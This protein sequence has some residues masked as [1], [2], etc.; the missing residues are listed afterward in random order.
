MKTIKLSAFLILL[1]SWSIVSA[2]NKIGQFDRSTAI[3]DCKHEGK[4]AYSEDNQTYT[5]SGS[6]TNMWFGSD[7]FQYLWTTIQG[8]FI[9]RTEVAFVGEGVDPH[10]KVGW[11][12]KNSLDP[13]SKHVNASTH[14][15]GLTSL[16]YRKEI[17]ADTEEVVSTA[18]HPDVIQLERKGNTFI[19]S[20]A[21]FGEEFT[22]VTLDAVQLDTEVYIGIYMCSHNPEVVESAIYRNVRIIKPVEPDFKPYRDYIGSNLEIMDVETGQREIIYQSAH[23]IQA[24]NWTVDGKK[25]IYNSKGRLYNYELATHSISSLN[26]GFAVNNNNDHVLTFDGKLLGISNHNQDDGGTSAIYYLPTEGDSLP[27]LVTKKGVG[28]SYFHGWSPDNK[29]MVFTGNRGGAYNIHTVD[30][31]SGKEEKLTDLTTLDDGPE[32]SPDGKHIFFNSARTGTMQLW[33]MKANGKKQTQL[34][35]DKYNDWFPHVSPDKKWIAFI[36]FPSDI[37]P[38]DHPFYKHCL[39]RIMP[40]EGGEPKVI[41][42]IYG[43]QGT[44][45]VPS[46]SPDSKKIAFVTNTRL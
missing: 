12:V 3:G 27:K 4:V 5:L 21:K 38:N 45:N 14:G 43:G 6:G 46:W 39:L 8:D 36:S 29:K 24:P 33:R 34:T 15:D 17:G 42:Y 35:F 18:T 7:E 19:M 40:Y 41:G 25:L 13:N 37:D 44:I 2:Q 1:L 9:L 20:T 11:I 22:S 10:R 31:D 30:V 23:S 16:Q 28:A 26:T 32:Y